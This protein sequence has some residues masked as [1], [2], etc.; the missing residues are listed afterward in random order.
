MPNV[1]VQ[2]RIKPNTRNVLEFT[3][4]K[5]T[6][7]SK[8]YTFEKVHNRIPQQQLFNSSVLSYIERF[9]SGEN[10]TI[11][12]YG[13][14]GSGKTYT[15]GLCSK[16]EKG[17]IQN[18]LEI[19]FKKGITLSCS[20][21]E[22]YNEDIYD[23]MTNERVSLNIRQSM[24]DIT[25]VGVQEYEVSSYADALEVLRRGSENRTTKSTKMNNESSRSHAMFTITYK[26]NIEDKF[27]ESKISFVDLAG[28]ERLKRTECKGNTARESI[29]INTGLLSLGNVINALYLKKPHVPF[30]DSKL[31]RILQK[32]LNGNVLLIAC[33]SGLQEDLFETTNTLKYASRAALISLK[34]KVCIENN[35]DKLTILNL[36]KEIS[37]LKD[38]NNRLR[39]GMVSSGWNN[40]KIKNHPLVV[41]LINR[42][43]AFESE[44][45]ISKIFNERLRYK[46]SS[47]NS[48]EDTVTLSPVPNIKK[49]ITFGK[50][51]L[52]PTPVEKQ[53]NFQ[54]VNVKSV[55]N[56]RSILNDKF[57]LKDKSTLNDKQLLKDKSVLDDKLLSND[58]PLLNENQANETVLNVTNL[59]ISNL[60]NELDTLNDDCNMKNK[61][62]SI[63]KAKIDENTVKKRTRLVSFDLEPKSK[64][65]LFTPLKESNSH[66]IT[67]ELKEVLND[68]SVISFEKYQNS[69]VFNCTDSKIRHYTVL[70]SCEPKIAVLVSDD[71]I[72]C[73]YTDE[74][75]YYSSRSLLKTYTSSGR[76]LPVHAYKTEISS[77]KISQNLVY[78]G[79]EDGF[80]NVIDLR[81]KELV[82]S[83]RIHNSAIFDICIDDSSFYTC[84]RDHDV[85][86][87][88]IGT[89]CS[90]ILKNPF[91]TLSPPHY[92]SV[93]KLINYKNKC[94][95][96]SRDCSIKVWNKDTPFK[97]IPY[98]H[99]SWIRTGTSTD[100]CFVT[101]C[102]NGLIKCWDFLDQSV[103][104][105]SKTDIGSSIT[106]MFSYDKELWVAAANKKIYRYEIDGV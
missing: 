21:I 37:A 42:L 33:I 98:A 80:L 27:V 101:G 10:C 90:G 99:D 76:P 48:V 29:S 73:I 79:H 104:C 28:S 38:E 9:I 89:N 84:S 65:V 87:C 86:Y 59:K 31:T 57:V 12:T 66:K 30:R 34:E 61:Y 51:S 82:F 45:T 52:N 83:N 17:I 100:R 62:S 46:D 18:S 44:E 26:Q 85:K 50:K 15:M 22:I 93:N 96:L 72:R 47:K 13:Q 41:E 68:Q 20:F 103:R 8:I 94:I 63:N 1:A 70:D 74:N 92:D 58:N 23:L 75:L 43:R 11:L 3:N 32:C 7:G 4:N 25:I 36:K 56:G 77:L 49:S 64:N 97:T 81:S 78:T 67:L 5:I 95:S 19:I 105:V 6:V 55:L 91:F 71:C 54:E 102:K 69:I 24:D 2:V 60:K 53:I 14:T 106:G 40:E 88:D 39:I 35:K 16:I